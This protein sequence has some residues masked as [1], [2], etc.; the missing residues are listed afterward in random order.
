MYDTVPSTESYVKESKRSK[1]LRT[2]SV[3]EKILA[4]FFSFNLLNIFQATVICQVRSERSTYES[5]MWRGEGRGLEASRGGCWW[6]F[7]PSVKPY[8]TI[9]LLT[10]T[11][12]TVFI[13]Y[14]CIDE[15]INNSP[16]VAQWISNNAKIQ[17]ATHVS[18]QIKL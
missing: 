4:F 8:S 14:I 1:I 2:V 13:V 6:L 10:T 16:S 15:K 12:F 11:M 17:T 3:W 9:L 7:Q 5:V 18:P